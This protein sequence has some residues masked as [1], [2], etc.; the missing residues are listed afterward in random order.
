MALLPTGYTELEYIE[1]TV[2]SSNNKC[3]QIIN[4]G[5]NFFSEY[6]NDP[7][8]WDQNNI[9]SI[10]C[11]M[12]LTANNITT[13]QGF[14]GAAYRKPGGTTAENLRR[15]FYGWY[16]PDG[17]RYN[18]R[19]GLVATLASA[20]TFSPNPSYNLGR[21]IYTYKYYATSSGDK[22]SK[23]EF[24]VTTTSGEAVTSIQPSGGH[25]YPGG[26]FDFINQPI[27]IFGYQ[28]NGSSTSAAN[29]NKQP[30]GCAVAKCY[31]FKITKSYN[32]V[33][34]VLVN[35]IPAKRNSDNEVGMYDIVR[36]QFFG[37]GNNDTTWSTYTGVP[38]T[39]G[40]EISYNSYTINASTDLNFGELSYKSIVDENSYV[41]I[42]YVQNNLLD[43]SYKVKK[44]YYKD[45]TD[46]WIELEGNS[47]SCTFTAISSM[48]V[49]NEI[50]IKAELEQ[51]GKCILL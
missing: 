21:Y 50:R 15:L 23:H 5:F 9:W 12:E 38:F 36:Q 24:Y 1:S 8:A 2:D 26:A 13:A 20:K 17:G 27:F 22:G 28:D 29:L 16:K 18:L 4:T 33:E 11:D 48:A 43:K 14:F 35:M 3:N 34:N 46:S 39:A 44:W 37:N 49:N 7:N 51:Y 41:T 47:R 19:A 32:G 31:N 30:T 6:Y 42:Y 25:P 45:S 40:G 10:T